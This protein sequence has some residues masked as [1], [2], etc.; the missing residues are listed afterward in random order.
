MLSEKC[1][2]F[3]LGLNVLKCITPMS[4]LWT[5]SITLQWHGHLKIPAYK[6][7]V[8]QLTEIYIKETTKGLHYWPYVRELSQHRIN[9]VE[10][11]S[12]S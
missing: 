7:F 12:V 4:Y 5:L 11:M 2:P 6:L 9:I 3:C 10:N 8:Q 1:G